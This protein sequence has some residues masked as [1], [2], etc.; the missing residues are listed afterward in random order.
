MV[1][2]EQD[3]WLYFAPP[4]TGT[5]TLRHYL[6]QP[7]FH[8]RLLTNAMNSPHD[9]A[10]PERKDGWRICYSTRHP[11]TRCLS[12]WQ[13][14]NVEGTAAQVTFGD[15]LRDAEEGRL[16]KLFAGSVS[17]WVAHLPAAVP[18]RLE[19]LAEDLYRFFRCPLPAIPQ[20]NASRHERLPHLDYLPRIESLYADDLAR[21]YAW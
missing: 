21:W 17:Q 18:L 9:V 6:T 7:P 16:S 1:C 2:N 5:T 14:F 15:W 3:G 11:F 20:L 19:T 13:F 4:K 12:L 10:I 8:G